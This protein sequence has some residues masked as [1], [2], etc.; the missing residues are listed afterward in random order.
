MS[1]TKN[2]FF[3]RFMGVKY[4]YSERSVSYGYDEIEKYEN[5]SLYENKNV[6]SLGFS[7][8]NLLNNEDYKKMS[9]IE[10]LLA[11]QN[12]IIIDGNSNNSNLNFNYDDIDFE[13]AKE[14]IG[15]KIVDIKNLKIKQIGNKYIYS[16]V[17]HSGKL[18]F[19]LDK[20]LKNKT[21]II[22]FNVNNY[23]DRHI[24]IT[25]NGIKNTLSDSLFSYYNDNKTFDY[26]ISS[27]SDIKKI[28]INFSKGYYEISDIQIYTVDNSFFDENNTTP[29]VI[30]FDKTKGDDIYGNINVSESGYFIFTI[31]YDKGYAAYV[32]NKEVEIEKVN[33]GFIGFKIEPGEHDIHLTFEAPY[34]KMGRLVSLIGIIVSIILCIY[35]KYKKK[36]N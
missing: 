9:F 3:N 31:P 8:S 5:I 34:A 6:Y 10:K 28:T 21:L 13:Y 15:Y 35:E 18:E 22:R 30:D 11:Y 19:L 33:G 23:F 16:D 7:L 29:L 26:V 12:N 24:S 14:N 4:L 20:P 17:K 1:A 36:D 32:D 2:I 25:I 27:T